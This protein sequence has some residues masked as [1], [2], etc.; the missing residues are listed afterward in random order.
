MQKL[1]FTTTI[2][3]SREKVWEVLW[4]HDS[5]KEWTRV[6]AEGSDVKTDGWK[7]G[8]KVLFGDATGNGMVSEIAD[9]RPGE[10]MSFRHLG[11]IKD[12]VED[13]T[14]DNVKAWSGA[15]ENYTLRDDNEGT[16]LTVEMDTADD[17]KDYFLQ[18]WPLAMQK[19]KELSERDN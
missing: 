9:N 15:K 13:F 19:I 6:F 2:Q 11:M 18:K 3:A 10:F 4:N 17:F 8:T 14:S 12:G 7:V 5:Y 16:H 1:N